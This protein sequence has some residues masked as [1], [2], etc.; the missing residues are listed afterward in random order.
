MSLHNPA[1]RYIPASA[2]GDPAAFARRQRERIRAAAEQ[3]K[4]APDK[5][6]QITKRRSA[7]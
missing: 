2:H 1:F 3:R 7:A 4:A 5:V 6:Q